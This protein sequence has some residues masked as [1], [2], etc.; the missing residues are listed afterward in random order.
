MNSPNI[1]I[2]GGSG[3]IG[4]YVIEEVSKKWP[5][6]NLFLMCRD[7]SRFK[8]D[9]DKETITLVEGSMDKIEALKDTLA[10]MDFLI[11]IAT[12]WGDYE[13][14]V[15]INV[16]KTQK[17]LGYLDANRIQRILYFSTASILGPGNTVIDEAGTEGT[18]YVRSKYLAYKALESHPLKNKIITLFPTAV[19]GGDSSHPYSHITE[20][21]PNSKKYL[22]LL[23][24]IYVDATFHF[25]HGKDIALVTAALLDFANP[26]PNYVLGNTQYSER[27]ACRILCK[28]FRIPIYFQLEVPTWFI[29]GLIKLL[30]I[31]LSAWDRYCITHPHFL[32]TTVNPSAFGLQP[33]YPQLEDVIKRL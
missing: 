23:R 12:E 8:I 30:K 11:H 14:T 21:L 22:K 15:T 18:P 5:K 6:A 10:K 32:Y 24:W 1:F 26:K 33:V 20:G 4:H 29:F 31:K 16:D 27:R 13:H 19:F 7:K 17:M 2:T 25:L 9:T 3:C 28:H